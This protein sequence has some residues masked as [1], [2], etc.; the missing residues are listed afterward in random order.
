MNDLGIPKTLEIP[1]RKCVCGTIMN[2]DA[3]RPYGCGGESGRRYCDYW[4]LRWECP[5]CN[6]Q[7]K[8]EV[9]IG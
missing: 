4:R 7:A 3:F 1:I 8:I 5:D 6:T 9:K 2:I